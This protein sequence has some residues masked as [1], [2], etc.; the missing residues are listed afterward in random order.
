[1]LIHGSINPLPNNKIL[2]VTKLKAFAD[3]K[4]NFAKMMIAL[5]DKIENTMRKGE[6][7]GDQHFLLFPRCFSQLSSLDS[8]KSRDCV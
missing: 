8:L 6:N 1:M 2:E 7:A 5:F 3:E 4:L